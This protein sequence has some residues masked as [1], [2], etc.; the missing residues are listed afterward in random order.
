MA[1]FVLLNPCFYCY[2]MCIYKYSLY[3]TVYFYKKK[4][5]HNDGYDGHER[6]TEIISTYNFLFTIFISA[7]NYFCY[8]RKS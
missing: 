8:N 6:L 2:G 1:M 3:D 4:F 7:M 5:I